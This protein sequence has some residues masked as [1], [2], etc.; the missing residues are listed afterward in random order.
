MNGFTLFRFRHARHP[1]DSRLIENGTLRG[2]LASFFV[3]LAVAPACARAS[4]NVLASTNDVDFGTVVY[5]SLATADAQGLK[6]MAARRRVTLTGICDTSQSAIRLA[7]SGL[8]PPVAGPTEPGSPYISWGADGVA[9]FRLLRAQVEDVPVLIAVEGDGLAFAPAV[10][11]GKNAIVDLDLSKLAPE[12]RKSF[13]LQIELAGALRA[14]AVVRTA[15]N[16]E[17]DFSVQILDT[18]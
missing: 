8:Q 15:Q 2:I 17:D 13:S 5:G 1:C 12:H 18:P 6:R 7:F 9:V 14:T 4:C 3:A 11:L 10:D 16:L